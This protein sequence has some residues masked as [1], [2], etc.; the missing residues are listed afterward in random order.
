M[1]GIAYLQTITD[2]GYMAL[3]VDLKSRKVVGRKLC[4]RLTTLLVDSISIRRS[5]MEPIEIHK[6]PQRA[7][8]SLHQQ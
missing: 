8:L 3:F 7:R 6:S 1:T 4:N 5:R 2:W